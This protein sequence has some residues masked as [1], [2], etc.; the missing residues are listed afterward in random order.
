M[1][2]VHALEMNCAIGRIASEVTEYSS[3]EC[4]KFGLRHFSRSHG[5]FAVLNRTEASDVARDRYV[6]G[7]ICK[8]HLCPG[9]TKQP[10]ISFRLGGIAAREAMRAEPPYVPRTGDRAAVGRLKR[11]ICSTISIAG[12]RQFAN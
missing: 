11:S 1:A 10:L 8:H 9:I 6:V 3:Q 4:C 5:E 2:P 12:K 7:R